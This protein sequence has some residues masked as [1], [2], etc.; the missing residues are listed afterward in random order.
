MTPTEMP[1]V[2]PLSL[3]RFAAELAMLAGA[4]WAGWVLG[5]RLPWGLVAAV[6]AP[7]LVAVVWGRWI[8]PRS[9]RRSADPR[10]FAVEAALFVATAVALVAAGQVVWA[11]LLVVGWLLSAPSDHGWPGRRRPSRTG[12]T[13]PAEQRGT[14]GTL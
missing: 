2:T 10:R 3:V 11:A 13:G 5:G 6:A 4:G 8:A 1:A 12:S 9:A 14:A 7:L